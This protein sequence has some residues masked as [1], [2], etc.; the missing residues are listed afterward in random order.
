MFEELKNINQKY[1]GQWIFMINCR[2]NDNGSIIGG[3]VILHSENR[4]K[5]IRDMEA[6]KSEP[7]L[8]SFRYAGKIPKG[9]SV[10][11]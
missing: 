7:S 8:T 3:E 9:V 5:V 2:E 6:F 1:D 10:I 11:L 4:D